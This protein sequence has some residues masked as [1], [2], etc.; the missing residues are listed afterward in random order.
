MANTLR[1]SWRIG[2][3][4][5][6]AVALSVAWPTLLAAEAP[7][8]YRLPAVDEQPAADA[9][10]P[11]ND[12]PSVD[13]STINAA[14]SVTPVDEPVE[15]TWQPQITKL[16][17]VNT[18]VEP[19]RVPPTPRPL[20]PIEQPPAA[21]PVEADEPAASRATNEATE[22]TPEMTE[23][24]ESDWSAGLEPPAEP[25]Q[26]N[27]QAAAP[28]P[29]PYA[30]TPYAPTTADLSRQLLPQVRKGY[31]LAQHGA[32]YAAQTEFIQVLRRIA[33]AKD[34]AENVDTHAQALAAG[35]RAL[36]EADDFAPR[37]AALE[38]DMNVPVIVSSHRTPVFD[39]QGGNAAAFRPAEAIALYHEYARREL[40]EAV[41]GEQAGSMA[42][43][44]LGK[45]QSR[46]AREA[47]GQLQHERKALVMY[48]AALDAGPGNH[49][50]ANEIGVLLARAGQPAAASQMFR[51]AIDIAPTSA[52]YHN[53]AVTDRA[54][55]YVAQAAA[56]EKYAM[57]LAHRERAA[58]SVSRA[59]G[60]EWVAPQDLSR[61]AQPM[62]NEANQDQ[63]AGRQIAPQPV[64]AVETA[65]KWPQKLIPGIFRR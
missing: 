12:K 36:D 6:L 33:E 55:G 48:A 19:P 15:S 47:D 42:L 14:D 25:E 45:V 51:Y 30:P 52:G 10:L 9:D 3:S 61:V 63:M 49:L 34:G 60:V 28:G 38:A 43:Y 46:L 1:Q 26:T 22:P 40:A 62:P 23:A 44:G 35:L 32:V 41:A 58:G 7:A 37:G 59:K 27:A 50:A 17:P 65:A 57:Q 29:T 21:K 11:I 5:A 20:P 18:R 8:M 4:A 24:L 16:P 56:N 39:S 54:Q 31:G 64:G 2:A 13:Q 53:L